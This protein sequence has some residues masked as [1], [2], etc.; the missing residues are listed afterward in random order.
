MRVSQQ[1]TISKDIEGWI[2]VDNLEWSA[3]RA[4]LITQ[5]QTWFIDYAELV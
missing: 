1:N 2:G 5:Q 4:L 3:E